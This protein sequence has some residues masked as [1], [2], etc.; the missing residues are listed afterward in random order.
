[1]SDKIEVSICVN[2]N[3]F[4]RSDLLYNGACQRCYN[5]CTMPAR[6]SLQPCYKCSVLTPKI[7][8]F[9]GIC[10]IC[11]KKC[12]EEKVKKT[13]KKKPKIDNKKERRIILD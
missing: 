6:T 3:D 11:F 2:C 1:M 12:C 4:I 9:D 5:K 10:S 7:R 8:L 13:K